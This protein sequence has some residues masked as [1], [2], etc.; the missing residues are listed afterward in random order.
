MRN[1]TTFTKMQNAERKERRK[2]I[3]PFWRVSVPSYPIPQQ[4]NAKMCAY[5]NNRGIMSKSAIVR[6]ARKILLIR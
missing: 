5:I 4:P 6:K 3:K 2:S 1:S